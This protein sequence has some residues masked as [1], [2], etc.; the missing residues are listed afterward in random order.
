MLYGCVFFWKQIRLKR[1]FVIATHT[2]ISSSIQRRFSPFSLLISVRAENPYSQS[3]EDANGN[4]IFTA[5]KPI[6]A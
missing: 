2:R 5:L 4:I 3:H 6:I 1:G